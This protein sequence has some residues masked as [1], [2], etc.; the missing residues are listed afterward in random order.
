MYHCTHILSEMINSKYSRKT[1]FFLNVLRMFRFDIS[2]RKSYLLV[3]FY[4]KIDEWFFGEKFNAKLCFDNI[5]I[6][7]HNFYCSNTQILVSLQS[8]ILLNQQRKRY[9]QPSVDSDISPRNSV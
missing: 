7:F 4:N 1:S 3:R 6:R 9:P 5:D 2:S 8:M